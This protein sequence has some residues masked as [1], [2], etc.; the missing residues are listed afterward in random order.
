MTDSFLDPLN[1]RRAWA[2]IDLDALAYNAAHLS[3]LLPE[4]CE[5]MAVV[6]AD[7]Y[8]HGAEKVA[9]RLM[10]EGVKS[11]AVAT[12]SEAVQLRE[13]GLEGEILILGYTHPRDATL[14]SAFSLSQLVVDSG[15]AKELNGANIPLNV[16]I[17]IDTGMHRLGIE[18]SDFSGIERVF[19]CKNLHVEGI[20]THLA[21]ADSI[22][23][24]EIEFTNNQMYKFL[25]VVEALR[26][27]GYNVGKIHTQSSYGIC[28]HPGIKCDIARA[29]I[30]LYG[31]MS[32]EDDTILKPALQPV[33]SLRAIVAQ[34]RRIGAGESISYGR[35][36][37]TGKPMKIATICIGYADGVPRRMS[38][39]KA[40]C[41]IGGRKV[42]IIGRICMDL[43][44]ADVTGIDSVRTG[45]VA[46]LI[47]KD[48]GAE[49]RCEDVAEASGTITNEILCRL[50]NRLPRVYTP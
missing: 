31:V 36:Y 44:M 40:V 4:N 12:V 42:P 32:R 35:T 1:Q 5:L 26:S 48:G 34:V 15:H 50:G 13:C 38:A 7:A 22:E 2:E 41:I 21:S 24:D 6:K 46:T 3:S 16:H 49:I 14:L 23:K 9:M 45:D 47:G 27:M 18:P 17:A 29:G 25:A 10:A 39:D 19:A 11:F 28:N 20:A 33:L 43:L 8:G 37:T 30:M